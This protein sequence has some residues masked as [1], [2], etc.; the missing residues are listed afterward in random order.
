MADRFSA[1]ER[2]PQQNPP[3]SGTP[4]PVEY[5]DWDSRFFGRRI[6]RVR[7]HHLNDHLVAAILEW[8][9]TQ[10]IDCLYFLA[11]AGDPEPSGWL[12]EMPSISLTSAL[13]SNAR[14][15][16]YPRSPL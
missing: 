16:A 3:P 6:A 15:K 1:F 9:S 12:N 11:D 13:P 10:R 5:L 4:E 8:C 7:G 2:P 14:W